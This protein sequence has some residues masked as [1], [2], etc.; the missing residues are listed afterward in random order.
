[1][2]SPADLT[3]A[4]SAHSVFWLYTMM[5]AFGAGALFFLYRA[6]KTGAVAD[7]EAPKYR[8]L[9]DDNAIGK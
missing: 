1:M 5:T 3:T 9:E 6:I 7:D 4:V 8:M 2:A